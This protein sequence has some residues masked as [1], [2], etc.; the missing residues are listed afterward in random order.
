MKRRSERVRRLGWIL[1]SLGLLGVM[2]CRTEEKRQQVA[3][4]VLPPEAGI[5]MLAY[6]TEFVKHA[7]RDAGTLGAARASRWIAQ[8]IKRMGLKPVADTWTEVTPQG[9]KTFCNLYVDFPGQSDSVVLVGSHYDT[10]AGI[11][12]GFEGANDGGSST[13]TLLALIEH[14]AERKV[15]LK[16]T[17]RFAFFDGEECFGEMYREN[18]GLHGSRR[19]AHYFATVRAEKPLFAVLV[20][21]MVGDANLHLTVPRNVSPWLALLAL[22]ESQHRKSVA[23]VSLGSSIVIDD[24]FPFLVE[25]FEALNLID[26]DYGSEPGLNNY[27]HTMED[28]IEKIHPYSLYRTGNLVLGILARIDAG[29][30]PPTERPSHTHGRGGR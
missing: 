21:D 1:L 15:K 28:T 25:G 17:I 5:R 11:G 2:G 26:F 13:G 4:D 14:L 29:A 3:W 12:E 19:M 18:D 20:I 24:H 6:T 30:A 23:P 27:W 22:E 9:P 16:H 10:K 7:P 8:E